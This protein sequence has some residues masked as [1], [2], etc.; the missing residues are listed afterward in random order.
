M[1]S[2]VLMSE[3]DDGE[4][5]RTGERSTSRSCADRVP[6]VRLENPAGGPSQ[7]QITLKDRVTS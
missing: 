1:R 5:V 4:R 7:I 3:R 2:S 6:P